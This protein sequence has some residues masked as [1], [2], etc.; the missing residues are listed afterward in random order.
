MKEVTWNSEGTQKVFESVKGWDIRIMWVFE[1]V[2]IDCGILCSLQT[3]E[4]EIQIFLLKW[5]KEVIKI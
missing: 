4:Q 2:D 3:Y 5:N 1:K